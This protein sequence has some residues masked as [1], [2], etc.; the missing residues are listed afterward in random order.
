MR[1]SLASIIGAMFLRLLAITILGLPLLSQDRIAAAAPAN[2]IEQLATSYTKHSASLPLRHLTKRANVPS[3]DQIVAMIDQNGQF[4]SRPSVFW[5]AFYDYPGPTAYFKVK[6]WGTQKFGARCNFYL[7]TDMLSN[8]DYQAM[9][10]GTPTEA[11]KELQIRHLSK[12]FARRSK[13]TVYVLV[14]D[15]KEPGDTSVWKVWEAPTLTRR[16]TW[17]NEIVRVGYPSGR[18]QSIWKTGDAALYD[19]APP[20]KV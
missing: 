3:T 9:N 16:P 1:A 8:A 10:S 14:P 7:Y 17:V 13:G 19:P 2:R 11:E 20:G 15:G 18:E 5:T 4:G 12:A 6:D